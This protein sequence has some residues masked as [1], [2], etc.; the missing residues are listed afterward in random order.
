MTSSPRHTYRSAA[1]LI[2][3]QDGQFLLARRYNTG[4]EDG[5]YSLVAGHV[6]EGETVTQAM[7]REAYEEAGIVID[8]AQLRVVHV[9]HRHNTDG[10]T[11]DFFLQTDVWTGTPTIAE[12]DKC[13]DIQWFAL[14]DLPDNV[15]PYIRSTLTLVQDQR[16]YSEFGWE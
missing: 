15:I 10:A 14:T 16:F 6:D 4:Y 5:K 13:D 9:M 7:V 2:L 1:H 3:E 12:P 11:F 8:P